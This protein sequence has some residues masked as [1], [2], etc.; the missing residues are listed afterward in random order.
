MSPVITLMNQITEG[1]IVLPGIQRD[2]VWD[3]ENIARLLDSILRGYPVGIA[4]LWETYN[5]IQYRPFVRDYVRGS[6]ATYAENTKRKK[7]KLV[8]DGQQRLQSLFIALYGTRNDRQL[9]F[10]VLSGRDSDDLSWQRYRFEFLKPAHA[11]ARNKSQREHWVPLA[12]IFTWQYS[13][14][15]AFRKEVTTAKA[16]SDEDAMRLD[17]NLGRLDDALMRDDNV[18]RVSTID[19]S[20][21]IDSPSRKTEA[22]VLEIFVR[23]NR[24]GTPLS[25]S[26]LIFSMLKLNWKE[27][28]VPLPEFLAKINTGNSLGLNTD[29]VIRCLFAASELG[30]KLDLDLLR[31]QSNVTKLQENFADCCAA[32]EA[33]IDF[34]IHECKCENDEL[35]G[36]LATLIPFVYYFYRLPN[37]QLPNNGIAV[38]RK[39]FYLIAL[40]RPFSRYGESRV[41][42][43][44]RDAIKPDLEAGELRLSVP[45]A[46][47]LIRRGERIVSMEGLLQANEVLALH[48]LQGLSGGKMQYA[49]NRPEI[50]HIF[51]RSVLREKNFAPDEINHVAN[52]WVLA[53]GKNRN[54]S[55][56]SPEK[57]FEDVDSDT[58]DVAAI[59]P[60]LLAA[61]Y[62]GYRRFLRVR[63]AAMAERVKSRIKLTDSELA[64]LGSETIDEDEFAP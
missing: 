13:D 2:F 39:V 9:Y 53:Q 28:A 64:L 19:E 7:I 42:A 18:L 20:L 62:R 29:F 8:L 24:E 56:K 35:V 54:K 15:A 14:R 34:V 61:G 23:I 63:M 5:D 52:Y 45:A 43:Y 48:L 6:L 22:D 41:W 37:H 4:L 31:K 46:L 27:A 30:A 50:D 11:A 10:D 44:I 12:H 49:A 47:G 51:P 21:P 33:T 16:L 55:D 36:G 59:D 1:D 60:D 25:R 3:E 58:L 40:A 38:A 57:Y 26:D 32:I 17:Y